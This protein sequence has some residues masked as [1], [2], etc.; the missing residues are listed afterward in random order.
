M[1]EGGGVKADSRVVGHKVVK[2]LTTHG[3]TGLDHRALAPL[4]GHG[5]RCGQGHQRVANHA[6]VHAQVL[7]VGQRFQ[8]GRLD[9]ADAYLDGVVISDQAGDIR[10]HCP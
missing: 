1:G 7:T 3:D 2:R 9:L 5:S 8:N 10:A 6:A 4:F